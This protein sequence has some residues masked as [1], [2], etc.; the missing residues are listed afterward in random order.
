MVER[1]NKVVSFTS[2]L[3]T[4]AGLIVAMSGL[5]WGILS[6]NVGE[7]NK[8]LDREDFQVYKAEVVTK[9]ASVGSSEKVATLC[10]DIDEIK[11]TLKD[12]VKSQQRMLQKLG[13][14]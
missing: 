4:V 1:S 10:E 14:P 2:H 7:L 8:K 6:W 3:L 13:M 5:A 11:E 12:V 9:F